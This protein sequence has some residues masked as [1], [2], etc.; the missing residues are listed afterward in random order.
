MVNCSSTTITPWHARARG[1]K[2]FS[3]WL[4]DSASTHA[5]PLSYALLLCPCTALQMLAPLMRPVSWLQ[6]QM[7]ALVAAEQVRWHVPLSNTHA[8]LD[9]HSMA[10]SRPST[11]V[12]SPPFP[13]I[14]AQCPQD[15]P[16]HREVL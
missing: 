12:A 9:T 6:Q 7:D 10:T 8:L 2:P 16:T 3:S 5:H 14:L 11:L 4:A 13:P 1:F 15:F